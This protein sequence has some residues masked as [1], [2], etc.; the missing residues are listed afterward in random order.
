M[1]LLLRALKFLICNKFYKNNLI[2]V[3]VSEYLF[4]EHYEIYAGFFLLAW[5]PEQQF[6]VVVVVGSWKFLQSNLLFKC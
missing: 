2:I 4:Y 5:S 6:I 1:L 3:V